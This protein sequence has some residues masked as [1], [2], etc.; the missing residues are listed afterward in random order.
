MAD[1]NTGGRQLG[2][3]LSA[4]LGETTPVTP[5]PVGGGGVTSLPIEKLSPGK[6]QPRRNFSEE[7]IV[8]LADSIRARGILQP[9][10]VRAAANKAGYYE[11]IAGERRW[12]AAQRAQ[13]HEIPVLVRDLGDEEALEVA[14]VENIQRSD[15][16]TLEEAEGYHR[17]M[18]EFSHTQE[19]LSG[20]IGKSRTHIANTLRLLTLPDAVKKLLE[21]GDLSAGHARTLVGLENAVEL[22]SQIVKKGLNVRQTEKLARRQKTG[23]AAPK[24]A[25]AVKDADTLAL[26]R[27][28]TDLLGLRVS[29]DFDGEGGKVTV[30]Y[31]TLD[32][33]D[34]IIRRLSDHR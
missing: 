28:L 21:S 8:S 7:D 2:R 10:L 33:L 26:E 31:K 34:D 4:L 3:G 20:V 1:K 13:L 22:A 18:E 25:G 27:T 29:V 14:L 6:F 24:P 5:D 17:L 19:S 16:N 23:T 11:I 12:R 30:E 15:L 32:Q 9:I